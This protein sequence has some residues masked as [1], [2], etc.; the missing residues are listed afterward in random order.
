MVTPELI[1]YIKSQLALGQSVENVKNILMANNWAE[2]DISEA[3]RRLT[4]ETNVSVQPAAS[5]QAQPASAPQASPSS[6]EPVTAV[7]PLV[8]GEPIKK[9]PETTPSATQIS[10]P[11]SQTGQPKPEPEF[12]T[13]SVISAAAGVTPASPVQETKS[14]IKEPALVKPVQTMPSSVKI[15]GRGLIKNK[16]E[17]IKI[18]LGVVIGIIIGLAASLGWGTIRK[19][20]LKSPIASPAPLS[21]TSP[22]PEIIPTP[23]PEFLSLTPYANTRHGFAL[24]YP[25]IWYLNESGYSDVVVVFYESEQGGPTV[26]AA[27]GTTTKTAVLESFVEAKLKEM[28]RSVPGY[29]VNSNSAM[30]VN[31]RPVRLVEANVSLGGISF[32]NLQ[33]Y[34]LSGNGTGIVFTAASLAGVWDQY[35]PLFLKMFQ[36][37]ELI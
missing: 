2:A 25:Q 17:V 8:S 13:P 31:G 24:Q 32:K 26:K 27:V 33:L 6:L 12:L 20:L 18:G 34:I 21:A 23:L 5:T 16:S 36:T 30:T 19:L 28:E 9:Q 14:E 4:G 37:V 10:E 29:T 22:P 11:V 3:L 7:S 35:K 1:T 15:S